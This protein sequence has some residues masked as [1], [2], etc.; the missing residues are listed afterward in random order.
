MLRYF[1]IGMDDLLR[2]AI[3]GLFYVPNLLDG[4]IK[5]IRFQFHYL[6][7]FMKKIV[8]LIFVLVF[9]VCSRA[10][11]EQ[12]EF[13]ASGLTCSMCSNAINK[14]LKTIGFVESVQTDLNKNMF[15]IKIRNAE[16]IDLDLVRK[17][18]EGAGFSVAKFWIIADFHGLQINRDDHLPIEGLN[19]H[20]M[21]VTPQVLEGKLRL[22]VI[23]RNFVLRKEF[24]S[25]AVMTH[26][27]Y[28]RGSKRPVVNLCTEV[29]P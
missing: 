22:Q 27:C 9:S 26:S 29:S 28:Q 15:T 23:D 12:L 10:Q 2:S 1:L 14:A 11:I 19:F 5:K 4:Q 25:Y 20:F 8:S 24:K 17:K 18:V 13:Q 7:D 21:N 3:S 16:P 6:R